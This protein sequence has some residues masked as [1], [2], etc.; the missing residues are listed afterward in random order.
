[1]TNKTGFGK[2]GKGHWYRLEIP[3]GTKGAA[4]LRQRD[5]L[6]GTGWSFQPVPMTFS[7]L[8]FPNPVLFV[9]FITVYSFIIAKRTQALQYYTFIGRSCSFSENI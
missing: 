3:T 7:L 2:K 8:F 9:I 4:T 6:F 1:M 5:I